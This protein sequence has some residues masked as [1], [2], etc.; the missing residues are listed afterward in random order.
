MILS[1]NGK[2]IPFCAVELGVGLQVE[3]GQNELL[4]VLQAPK[5][6]DDLEY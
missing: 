5:K 2:D 3:L 4:K 1:M 6:W